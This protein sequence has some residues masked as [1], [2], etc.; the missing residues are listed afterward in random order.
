MF[1]R[2]DDI[3]LAAKLETQELEER[4]LQSALTNAGLIDD[5]ADESG[6]VFPLPTSSQIIRIVAGYDTRKTT[7]QKVRC[8]ACKQHQPHFRG[9]RVELDTGQQARIGL[10]CGEKH[11]G[12]G[13]WQ[14][15]VSDY[16]RRAEN[17][18]YVSRIEPAI[19]SIGKTMPVLR[20]WH[21]RTN[22]F[23]S[24]I[25][26]FSRDVPKLF[27][28][29]VEEAKL[30]DGRLERQRR[31]KQNSVNRQGASGQKAAYETI[32]IGQIPYPDMFIGSSPNHGLNEAQTHFGLAV[33][34][35]ENKRDTASLAKAFRH[36]QDA[37]RQLQHAADVH[38]KIR[39]NL[40][41]DWIPSL[42]AWANR[43]ERLE[44]SY[45]AMNNGIL[46]DE[47]GSEEIFEFVNLD[48]LGLPMFGVI[49]AIWNSH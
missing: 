42:C 17:A 28:R 32:L 25:V 1:V 29:L 35:L 7:N 41:L 40:K 43:D 27:T 10:D 24:W 44:A 22:I 34:L 36:I 12:E 13:T 15:A 19:A 33:A 18:V 26:S 16:E 31:V 49:D 21:G 8:S 47:M 9:F 39:A 5:T 4:H 6:V 2:M 46:H 30:R 45:R 3:N 48:A 23:G 20:E 14:S 11:F 38:S 37:R